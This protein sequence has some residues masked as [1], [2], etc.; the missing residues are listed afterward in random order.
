LETDEWVRRWA[1]GR[2][3]FHRATVQPWLVE[4]AARFLPRG[5]E[6][7]FVP[8]CGKSVDLLWLEQRGHPVVG[9]EI[10]EQACRDFLR[11]HGRVAAEHP[12]PPFHVFSSG[13]IELL[14][15]DFF[16]FER[17][18]HGDFPAILDRA[19][20][21]AL[22]AARREEYARRILTLLRPGGRM[23]LVGVEYDES[24]MAGPP[25]SVTRA[26]VARHYGAACTIE[27][28]GEHDVAR[29][30]PVWKERG[31]ETITEYAL[32]IVRRR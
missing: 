1:E 26:E 27:P 6:C 12:S 20:L 7:V 30:E 10:A 19:A 28:L 29:S 15:G 32:L 4:A 5:D 17:D 14:C 21:I 8:L 16:A 18:R 3:C 13:R 2:I 25:F 11:E 23:L 22:P 31:L 24:K 9:V